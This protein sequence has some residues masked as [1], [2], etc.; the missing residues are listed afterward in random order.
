MTRKLNAAKIGSG[1]VCT[2]KM[3][4]LMRQSQYPK[5]SVMVGIAPES[6]GLA[7]AQRMVVGHEDMIFDVASI[8]SK[9]EPTRRAP[10]LS[11]HVW[12]KVNGPTNKCN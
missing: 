10:L 12:P 9:R 6:D 2:D 7:L 4:K 11:E 8:C 5:L 3:I 1:N